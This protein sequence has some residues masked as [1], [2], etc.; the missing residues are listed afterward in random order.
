[1][2]LSVHLF[3]VVWVAALLSFILCQDNCRVQDGKAGQPGISGKDGWPGQKGEK[4]EPGLLVQ[5]SMQELTAFKG[6][7]GEDGP[8]GDIGPKGLP[9]VLGPEGPIGPTGNQGSSIDSEVSNT[10]KAAFTVTRKKNEYPRYNSPLIFTEQLINLN[11]DFNIQ[12]GYFTCKIPGMYYF[13]FHFV[14]EGDLC[15]KLMS[16]NS[17]R[18]TLSFCDFNKRT[19]SVSQVMSGGFVIELAKGNKVWIQPFK[20]PEHNTETYKMSKTEKSVFNGFL[21]FATG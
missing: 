16:D 1:M 5:K 2:Q 21:I 20:N 14:S 4:G 17:A 6:D 8:I 15:V 19:S 7:K 9:G 12:T 11:S 18:V 3:A 10:K 13:V